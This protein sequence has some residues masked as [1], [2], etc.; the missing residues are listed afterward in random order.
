MSW[1]PE[2]KTSPSQAYHVFKTAAVLSA[3]NL[4]RLQRSSRVCPIRLSAAALAER[5]T[6]AW[7]KLNLREHPTASLSPTRQDT[8]TRYPL[9]SGSRWTSPENAVFHVL[10]LLTV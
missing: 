2:K 3:L 7:G 8:V 4:W 9:T 5:S 6:H 10:L 1:R